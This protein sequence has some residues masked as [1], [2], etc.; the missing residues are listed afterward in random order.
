MDTAP[1]GTSQDIQN[2]VDAAEAAFKGWWGTPPAQRAE[3]LGKAAHL[4]RE[5]EQ[6]LATLL[7]KEQGKPVRESV[8]ELAPLPQYVRALRWAREE[9]PWLLCSPLGAQ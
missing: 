2:A 9:P 5:Q 8:L 6:D 1:D 3:V 4:V 7:T